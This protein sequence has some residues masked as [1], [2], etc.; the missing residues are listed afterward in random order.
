MTTARG[1][2]KQKPNDLVST[3]A[4]RQSAPPERGRALPLWTK[5]MTRAA[6]GLLFTYHAL[7]L[8]LGTLIPRDSHLYTD[9]NPLFRPYLAIS[10]TEQIWNMF[11]TV[12][13]YASYDIVLFA[14]DS[15]NGQHEYGPIL[16]G[17][18]ACD[19]WN[20]RDNKLFGNLATP[21]YASVR[22]AYFETARRE[23]EARDRLKLRSLRLRF[24]TQRLF[25]L[26]RVR[27]TGRISFPEVTD[28][29][30]RRW[31]T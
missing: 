1:P 11:I 3:Q 6:L 24:K 28:T 13:N 12:P 9:L 14:E 23:I 30:P 16:P 4:R 20:Y 10:G 8:T 31:P 21:G 17:L 5:M 22:N 29:E 27:S 2:T 18:R 7:A 26:A 25:N 15:R 19:S